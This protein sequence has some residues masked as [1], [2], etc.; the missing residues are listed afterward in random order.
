MNNRLQQPLVTEYDGCVA[1]I[2]Y[3]VGVEPLAYVS[4]LNILSGRAWI[5]SVGVEM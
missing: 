1:T 3:A 4:C 2:L 5:F